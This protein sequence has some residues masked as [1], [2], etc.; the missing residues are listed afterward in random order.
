MTSGEGYNWLICIETP[1]EGLL[2]LDLL[3]MAHSIRKNIYHAF[4]CQLTKQ[5]EII[6]HISGSTKQSAQ[7]GQRSLRKKNYLH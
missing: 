1:A 5:L 4:C 6:A 3:F 2:Y 7:R